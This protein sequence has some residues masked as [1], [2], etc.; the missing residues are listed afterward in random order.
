[1]IEFVKR[2]RKDQTETSDRKI[3]RSTCNFYRVVFSHC[4]FG[5]KEGPQSILDIYYAQNIDSNGIWSIIS[6][7]K[8]QNKAIEACQQH[9][10][11]R[12]EQK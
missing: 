10:K 2:C 8:K 6:R 9:S 12:M 7:H 5:P 4:R 11:K 1:M 3:W